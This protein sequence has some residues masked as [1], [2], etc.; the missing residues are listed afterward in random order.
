MK[1]YI[2]PAIALWGIMS[3]REL[4]SGSPSINPNRR[5]DNPSLFD[6]KSNDFY[7]DCETTEGTGYPVYN[8]WED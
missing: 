5:V 8:P 2:K 4:L 7:A 6:A 3:K 1:H